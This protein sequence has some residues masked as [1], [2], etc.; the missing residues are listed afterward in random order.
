[1]DQEPERIVSSVCRRR[2]CGKRRKKKQQAAGSPRRDPIARALQ[3][4]NKSCGFGR[5]LDLACVSVQDLDF[6]CVSGP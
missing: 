3:F 6:V 2:K 1:M 5:R 4:R